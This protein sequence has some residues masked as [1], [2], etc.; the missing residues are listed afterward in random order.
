MFHINRSL[1]TE[2]GETC[3]CGVSVWQILL[4]SN[5]IVFIAIRCIPYKYQ[6][7]KQMDTQKGRLRVVFFARFHIDPLQFFAWQS[8]R[9]I[10]HFEFRKT[11]KRI[12]FTRIYYYHTFTHRPCGVTLRDWLSNADICRVRGVGSMMMLLFKL[13]VQNVFSKYF[14]QAGAK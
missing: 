9:S 8:S 6:L 2:R 12:V 5:D 1:Q 11:R 4:T 7:P 3:V 10:S 14:A 13:F